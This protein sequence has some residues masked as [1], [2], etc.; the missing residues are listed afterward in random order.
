MENTELIEKVAHIEER[1]KSNTKRLDEIETEVK[2]N[3][4]LTVAVKEIAT[5]MRYLR[6][7]QNKM[8]E[9]LKLIE[10]KPLKEY[11]NTKSQI[12]KQVISFFVGIALTAIGFILGLSKFM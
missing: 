8:N 1:A 4:E 6:E 11:E 3:R 7:E 12:K 2:E 10:E 9:R 5:E